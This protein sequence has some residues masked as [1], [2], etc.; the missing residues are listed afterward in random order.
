MR[1]NR[2]LLE[3]AGGMHLTERAPVGTAR[4]AGSHEANR[5]SP[6]VVAVEYFQIDGSMP[7]QLQDATSCILPQVLRLVNLACVLAIS[8]FCLYNIVLSFFC[9]RMHREG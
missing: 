7:G 3:S 9:S 5:P 1:I 4:L 6:K 8:I 2:N